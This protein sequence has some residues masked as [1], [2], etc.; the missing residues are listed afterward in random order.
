MQPINPGCAANRRSVIYFCRCIPPLSR[1]GYRAASATSQVILEGCIQP[2]PVG[3]IL[4]RRRREEQ[5]LMI[6]AGGSFVAVSRR[7][8]IYEP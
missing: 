5:T 8:N 3:E 1:T 2:F 4:R 6:A 7:R